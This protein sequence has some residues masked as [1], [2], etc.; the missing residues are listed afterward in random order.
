MLDVPELV[1]TKQMDAWITDFNSWDLCD[2]T[3]MNLF[4]KHP[5]AYKKAS[6]WTSLEPEFERR[7]GFSLMAVLAWHDKSA[8]DCKFEEFFP[9][10]KKHSIDERNFVKKAVNWS[11]RQIGKRN[12]VLCRKSIIIA[13]ELIKSDSK[14]ARW[15]GHDALKELT[16][17]Q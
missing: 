2:Q 5:A 3:C 4:W 15:I 6:E 8:C 16:G 10:I 12:A 11:L 13:E 14:S 1:T 7:A 17:R 9:Y